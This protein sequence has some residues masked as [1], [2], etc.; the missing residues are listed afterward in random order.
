MRDWRSL[1]NR[2]M[3]AYLANHQKKKRL[4][5][6]RER[7][8]LHALGNDLSDA[9]IIKAAEACM[10]K[11]KF[12]I[13]GEFGFQKDRASADKLRA[14]AMEFDDTTFDPWA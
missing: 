3:T 14:L 9:R 1:G 2:T 6:K 5:A 10:T 11:A 4:L 7:E 13:E 8:L 12:L